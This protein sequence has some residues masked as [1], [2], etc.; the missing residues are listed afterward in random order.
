MS[1]AHFTNLHEMRWP[2]MRMIRESREDA[3]GGPLCYERDEAGVASG[4]NPP[5]RHCS[6]RIA[7]LLVARVR[8]TTQRFSRLA[9]HPGTV[10][11]HSRRLVK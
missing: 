7:A 4:A 8:S 11:S 1:G 3:K 10:P 6:G 2:Q 9:L 5:G